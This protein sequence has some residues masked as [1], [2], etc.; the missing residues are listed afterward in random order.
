M[1]LSNGGVEGLALLNG[2]AELQRSGLAAAI[3]GGE[4][5]GA[6]DDMSVLKFSSLRVS[7]LTPWGTTVDLLKVGQLSE[8]SLVAERNVDEAVVNQSG[9]A[10]DGGGLLATT[11]GTGAD[12]HAG[13]LAPEA[14]LLPLLAGLVPEGLELGREVSVT[15]GNTE[16]DTVEGLKLGGIIQ[17]GD[18]GGLGRRVHLSK[19]LLGEGL[20]DLEEG[21]IATSLAD[22][23]ELSLGLWLGQ[24]SGG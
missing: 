15:G 10:G 4:S 8:S 18:V 21:G 11:E 2:N 14:A 6:L 13:V 22:A 3:T 19:D 16:E 20:G 1:S 23:L 7:Q 24:Q 12:E 9:H 17:G 5:S